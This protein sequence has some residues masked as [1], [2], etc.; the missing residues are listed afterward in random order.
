[1]GP[2]KPVKRILLADDEAGIRKV[3]GMS[4]SDM[5]YAVETA[6]D[7]RQA[8]ALFEARRHPIVLTDIKMPAM[9]GIAL[10]RRIKDVRPET[11]VIMI[12]GHG[13]LDLA[14]ESIKNDATDFVTKPIND[15]VLQIALGRAE[16]RILMRAELRRYTENLERLVAEKSAQVVEA[17]KMAAVG[18]TVAD[19]SHAIKNIAG[20]LKGGAF[21]L[22]KGIE[23]SDKQYLME[24]WRMIRGNVDKITK[25]SLDLLDYAKSAHMNFQPCD[26]DDLAREVAE[27]MEQ[28]C[29]SHQ[30]R[31]RLDLAFNQRAR[32]ESEAES[33]AGSGAVFESGADVADLSEAPAQAVAADADRA[34]PDGLIRLDPDAI[35]RCLLN[36][37]A[38]AIDALKG[39]FTPA[40]GQKR[41][42]IETRRAPDGGVAYRV[43]D[44]GRGM[45]ESVRERIF[46]SFFTTKGSEGSGIGLML[47]QKIADEHGGAISVDS[48]PEKGARV[49]LRLP[50]NPG[51]PPALRAPR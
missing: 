6:A 31:L 29:R 37:V 18:Q 47:T 35:H 50:K 25:L 36:L 14:I 45:S 49:T 34:L 22:E 38:N 2:S 46:K 40:D 16:E 11:E 23:L 30:I 44:N 1:M 7:G 4:L 17:E 27:L 51:K 8:L 9:D 13:D 15:D 10:L 41:I 5:G 12:T 32:S 48:A 39:D 3:L 19:L 24:G 26:P 33:E 43:S 42:I 21:V 20:G 28:R